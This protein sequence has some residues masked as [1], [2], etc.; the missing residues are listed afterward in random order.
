MREQPR[1]EYRGFS[2]G[3]VFIA[4][5]TGAAAG[6]AVAYFTAPAAGT[7]SRRRIRTAVDETRDGVARVPEA[8]RKA[9]EAAREAFVETLAKDG[10]RA[11]G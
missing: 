5:L 10:A 2:F 11:G 1:I 8:L 3:Q 7:E 9:T 4:A 6:A